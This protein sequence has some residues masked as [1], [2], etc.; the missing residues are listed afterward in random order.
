MPQARRPKDARQSERQ[1][2]CYRSEIS[3]PDFA[4]VDALFVNLSPQGCMIRCMREAPCGTALSFTLP[5]LGAW[6]G[7]VVWAIGA[8]MGIEF[9]REIPVDAYFPVLDQMMR[10][11]DEMGSC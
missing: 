3:G 5:E 6:Q 9:D 10:P 8:R 7:T 11:G 4:P 2:V 1:Q